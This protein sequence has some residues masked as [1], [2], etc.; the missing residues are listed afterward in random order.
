MLMNKYKTFTQEFQFL[1]PPKKIV[2]L[3][4]T[5]IYDMLLWISFVFYDL[6]FLVETNATKLRHLQTSSDL[7]A[8]GGVPSVR[9]I[10]MFV[11]NA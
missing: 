9:G 6:V 1:P 11:I 2:T 3:M 10:T 7:V 8:I 5:N 4:F